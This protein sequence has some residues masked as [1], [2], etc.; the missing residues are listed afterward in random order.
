MGNNI[1]TLK[2]L[3]VVILYNKDIADSATIKSLI[4]LGIRNSSIHIINNG[5]KAIEF[6]DSICDKFST[7]N[8]ISF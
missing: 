3:I 4:D 8:N 2:T 7:K 6:N 5:P 1:N